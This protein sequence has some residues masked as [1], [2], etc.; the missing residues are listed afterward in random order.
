MEAIKKQLTKE[1][2]QACIDFLN[3]G[4]VSVFKTLSYT[5]KATLYEAIDNMYMEAWKELQLLTAKTDTYK[6]LADVLSNVLFS[7]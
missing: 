4:N 5:D 6:C 1:Q 2:A 7:F 3:G